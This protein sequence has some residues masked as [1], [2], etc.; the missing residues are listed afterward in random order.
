M[1]HTSYYDKYKGNAG[2]CI[3][4]E[5]PQGFKGFK[6]DA[7]FPPK[8]LEVWY[9]TWEQ[10]Y[11]EEFATTGDHKQFRTNMKLLKKNY[12][13]QYRE[14]ILARIDVH[15]V[16]KALDGKVMLGWN[17]SGVFCHR[18]IIAEWLRAAGYDCK[19]LVYSQELKGTSK[20]KRRK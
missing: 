14:E 10:F 3:T 20:R 4:T 13:T 18:H 6:C 15:S 9:N 2:C 17:R 8:S 5:I 1:I 11:K 12:A 19:E 7:L 16:G